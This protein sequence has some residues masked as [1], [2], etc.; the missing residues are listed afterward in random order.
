MPPHSKRPPTS[1]T[2]E[3]SAWSISWTVFPTIPNAPI[4]AASPATGAP[5]TSPILGEARAGFWIRAVPARA[6]GGPLGGGG[7][8][9]RG[10]VGIGGPGGGAR[11]LRQWAHQR[12][13]RVAPDP[14][15]GRR[16][17]ASAPGKDRA[18]HGHA[19]LAAHAP[20]APPN[21]L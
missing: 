5:S 18:R 13:P 4:T 12:P 6:A 7:G 2:R 20:P 21:G 8:E 14:Q 17:P 10:G 16:L 11:P 1:P 19:G 9:G 15:E 3:A